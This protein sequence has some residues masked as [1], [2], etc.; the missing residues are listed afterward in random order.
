MKSPILVIN[1]GNTSTKI[2]IFDME[3]PVFVESIKH[4]D[5]ELQSF[6][7]INE[8]IG[9]R[10][11]MVLDFLNEK[12]IDIHDLKAVS[13]RGGLLKPSKSGTY[14]VNP[15]MIEDLGPI[16]QFYGTPVGPDHLKGEPG[17][18]RQQFVYI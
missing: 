14:L 15:E 2:A 18:P 5:E 17:D 4:S 16:D 8:Q 6:N 9:F 13:A 10:E 1:T 12:D 7:N 3:E 11:K